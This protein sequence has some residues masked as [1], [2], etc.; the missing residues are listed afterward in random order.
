MGL[1]MQ[2]GFCQEEIEGTDSD[3]LERNHSLLM[4][5]TVQQA[6]S[7]KIKCFFDPGLCQRLYVMIHKVKSIECSTSPMV[8]EANL[9]SF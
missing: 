6:V 4:M 2:S 5:M 9:I 8:R 3:T 7:I 1:L